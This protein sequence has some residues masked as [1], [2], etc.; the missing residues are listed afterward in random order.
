MSLSQETFGAFV[1][2]AETKAMCLKLQD[3][4]LAIKSLVLNDLKHAALGGGAD[5]IKVC[6][7][8]DHVARL[9]LALAEHALLFASERRRNR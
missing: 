8:E 6:E 9:A 5:G 1:N 4:I 7:Q 3:A 2:D